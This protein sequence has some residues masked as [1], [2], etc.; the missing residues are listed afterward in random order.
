VLDKAEFSFTSLEDVI[1]FLSNPS[2][3]TIADG[4]GGFFRGGFFGVTFNMMDSTA[5]SL[6]HRKLI[7]STVHQ[8]T[9]LL[10]EALTSDKLKQQ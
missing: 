6:N 8:Y 5:Q 1:S 3:F 9:Q 10:N 2:T 4:F 7:I